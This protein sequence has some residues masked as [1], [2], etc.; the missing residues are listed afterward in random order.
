[1][2]FLEMIPYFKHEIVDSLL[3]LRWAL[4]F[5]KGSEGLALESSLNQ[6][7]LNGL[8]LIQQ[9]PGFRELSPQA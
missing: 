7:T 8:I 9:T 2:R 3:H 6:F 4:L 5:Y 1:M